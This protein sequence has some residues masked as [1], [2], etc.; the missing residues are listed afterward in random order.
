MYEVSRTDFLRQYIVLNLYKIIVTF[1]YT[2]NIAI[3]E[4][5]VVII[6]IKHHA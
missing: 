3:P 4:R 2:N 1:F 6:S 5:V